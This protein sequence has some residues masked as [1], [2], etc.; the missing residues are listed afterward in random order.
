MLGL[1]IAKR[2]LM[3][4]IG[5]GIFGG[6]RGKISNLVGTS[7]KGRD[8]MRGWDERPEHIATRSQLDQRAIFSFARF[9]ASECRQLAG[10]LYSNKREKSIGQWAF[11]VKVWENAVDKNGLLFRYKLQ[12]AP[13]RMRARSV[14]AF[15]NSPNK[16][17]FRVAL[18]PYAP[19]N[20]DGNTIIFCVFY[21]NKTQKYVKEN[22]GL[23]D[24]TF[25]NF[26][27]YDNAL[28][29]NDEIVVYVIGASSRS[30]YQTEIGYST[31][32]YLED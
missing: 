27:I 13:I 8:V 30:K 5:K 6:F 11:S 23:F 29:D 3:A 18:N 12:F 32:M 1:E 2:I 16:K 20:Y 31:F 4:L 9:Y 19:D 10:L 14:V 15:N 22:S 26:S 21:W 24:S 25:W 7:W 17:S 28:Q